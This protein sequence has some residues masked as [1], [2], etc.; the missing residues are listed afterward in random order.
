MSILFT[1]FTHLSCLLTVAI[2][3]I[4][5][6]LPFIYAL[7]VEILVCAMDV[8]EAGPLMIYISNMRSDAQQLACNHV[9]M[10]HPPCIIIV[11]PSFIPAS[12]V[13]FT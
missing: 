1:L 10:Y 2:D 3:P 6:S 13:I 8:K 9:L 11:N 4:L 5:D 12:F 7:L